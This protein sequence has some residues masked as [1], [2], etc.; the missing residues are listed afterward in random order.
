MADP[1][2]KRLEYGLGDLPSRRIHLYLESHHVATCGSTDQTRSNII[3]GFV[4]GSYVAWIR[5][6]IEHLFMVFSC[7]TDGESRS[8]LSRRRKG[9]WTDRSSERSSRDDAEG[10]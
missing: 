6:V 4:H 7:T 8:E 9:S 3:V 2:P 1:H 10:S 5:V